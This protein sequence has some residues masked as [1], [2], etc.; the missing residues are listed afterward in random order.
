[1]DDAPA[2][3]AVKSACDA[4]PVGTPVSTSQLGWIQMLK[5]Q[6]KFMCS[7]EM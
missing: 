2:H 1:M 6:D 7:G 4:T 5:K 3:M